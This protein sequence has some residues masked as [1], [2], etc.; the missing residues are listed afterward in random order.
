MMFI[1]I[2]NCENKFAGKRV[3][4]IKRGSDE[5]GPGVRREY[6]NIKSGA[7]GRGRVEER[8]SEEYGE[9]VGEL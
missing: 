7:R 9:D 3:N 2:N 8:K 5:G 4:R 1:I 6:L